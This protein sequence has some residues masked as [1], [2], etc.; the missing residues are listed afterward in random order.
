ML[1]DVAYYKPRGVPLSMLQCVE[2]A[3][4]E[5][6]ALR[7]ADLEGL[8]QDEAA[9]RMNVSRQTFGRIIEAAHKKVA[10]ALVHGKALS[11]EGGPVEV[12][13]PEAAEPDPDVRRGRAGGPMGR[14]HCCRRRGRRRSRGGLSE[15]AS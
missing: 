1:P 5:L 9:Q 8:Y 12:A 14:P 3:V 6:E 4:D 11:I 13:G 2:L 10:D 7:L 15:S